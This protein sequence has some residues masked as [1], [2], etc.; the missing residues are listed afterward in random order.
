MNAASVKQVRCTIYTRVFD[1]GR[2]QI[3]EN[4]KRG[5]RR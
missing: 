1:I 4:A 2:R 3:G 5:A